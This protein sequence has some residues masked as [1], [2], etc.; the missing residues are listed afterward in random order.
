MEKSKDICCVCKTRTSRR[1]SP[2]K[3]YEKDFESCFK[4]CDS[5]CQGKLCD[6]CKGCVYSFRRNL[7]KDEKDKKDF[8]WQVDSCV[9]KAGVAKQR[10]KLVFSTSS[11]QKCMGKEIQSTSSVF[12]FCVL[13]EQVIVNVLSYLSLPDFTSFACSSKNNYRIYRLTRNLQH[14]YL[15]QL[16]NSSVT[17]SPITET[18]EIIFRKLVKKKLVQ[19]SDGLVRAKNKHGRPL[20][21]Y[22]LL[23]NQAI[24]LP[25]QQ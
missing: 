9:G 15:K 23:K 11:E 7:D 3:S 21:L 17:M 16:T 12:E 20:L 4:L 19:S 18:E 1:F 6:T 8:S 13:L 2:S 10:R 5:T 25:A 22:V 14:E 24:L